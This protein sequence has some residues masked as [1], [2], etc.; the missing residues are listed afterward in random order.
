M[1]QIE[2]ENNR[3][4]EMKTVIE[5]LSWRLRPEIASEIEKNKHN[6]IVNI[7][8]EQVKAMEKIFEE[9]NA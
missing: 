6:N 2:D 4:D 3:I 1:N 9:D 5:S 7:P 8:P